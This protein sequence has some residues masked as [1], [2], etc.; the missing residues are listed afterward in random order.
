MTLF[1]AGAYVAW[2]LFDHVQARVTLWLDP[3]SPE[4]LATSDQLA[5]G[6]MGMSAGGLFG[7]GLGRGRPWMTPF[8]DSDFIFTSL[9]E[10]LGLFGVFALLMLFGL[11]VQRGIRTSIGVRDGFGT[12]LAIGLAFSVGLQTFVVIGGVTGVIPLT[13]LTTPFMSQGGSALLANWIITAILLR[14]SDQ[15]RRP[16]PAL[17]EPVGEQPSTAEPTQVVSLR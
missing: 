6:I 9:G 2:F 17:A 16:T 15:A 7:T 13:G 11:F 3:F 5:K 4:A 14:I 8:P 1:C 10:E 12:L